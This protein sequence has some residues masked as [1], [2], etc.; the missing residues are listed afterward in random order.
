MDKL[1]LDEA[2]S[3]VAIDT[4]LGFVKGKLLESTRGLVDAAAKGEMPDTDD[5]LSQAKNL[6]GVRSE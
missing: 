4:V 3:Q 5:L 2:T 6:L 1:G